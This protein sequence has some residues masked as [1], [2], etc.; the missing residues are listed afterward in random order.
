[1]KKI[2][3]AMFDRGGEHVEELEQLKI[4]EE[5]G[6]DIASVNL[7]APLGAEIID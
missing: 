1:L 5:L 2:E 6:Q 3:Q 4:L 7:L